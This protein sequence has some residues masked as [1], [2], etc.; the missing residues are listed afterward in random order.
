MRS[1][2]HLRGFTCV[3]RRHAQRDVQTRSKQL[4]GAAW[5]HF[6]PRALGHAATVGPP[7]TSALNQQKAQPSK[8]LLAQSFEL[9][10]CSD[11]KSLKVVAGVELGEQVGHARNLGLTLCDCAASRW[12]RRGSKP[13]CVNTQ[14][15]RWRARTG[16]IMLCVGCAVSKVEGRVWTLPRCHALRAAQQAL[17]PGSLTPSAHMPSPPSQAPTPPCLHTTTSPE[18]V[19]VSP[20]TCTAIENSRAGCRGSTCACAH[21]A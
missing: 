21:A 19:C 2:W 18:Y 13:Q 11:H 16:E 4:W 1:T 12:E 3:C 20:C 8:S 14:C 7:S 5:P 17:T 15:Q 10:P 9:A 6:P